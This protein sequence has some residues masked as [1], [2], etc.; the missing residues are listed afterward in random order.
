V[1]FFLTLPNVPGKPKKVSGFVDT[2]LIDEAK[3]NLEFY[4][5]PDKFRDY[6]DKKAAKK[7]ANDYD[8]FIAQATLMKDIAASFGRI[9]GSRGKCLILR[10]AWLC[11]LGRS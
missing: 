1:D 6:K 8:Y 10:R 11:L 4:L 9:L 3:Q 2:E 7:L 5:T